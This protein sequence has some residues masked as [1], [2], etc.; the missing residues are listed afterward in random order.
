MDASTVATIASSS[1]W[2]TALTLDTTTTAN[3]GAGGIF[4]TSACSGSGTLRA[5]CILFTRATGALTGT[6]A[7]NVAFGTG[8]GTDWIKNPTGVGAFYVRI[9]MFSDVTYTTQIDSAAVAGS[10]NENIDITSKVQ[11]KLNFSV[12]GVYSAPTGACVALSGSGAVNLGDVVNG[13]LDTALAYD[14]HTYFRLNTNANGGTNV[15]YSGDTLKNIAGTNSITALTS[16]A[17]ASAVGSS[18]FGLALDTGNA[19]HSFTNLIATAP[20]AG[21]SGT[22]TNAGSALFAFS[23]ASV[24]TPVQIAGLASGTVSCDTGD[25]R[26]L[27]NIATTTKLV[28]T[29]LL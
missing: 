23:T 8:A 3:A 16:T 18:Q 9:Y 2:T 11:E 1:G 27:G 21:G 20:Y 24:T 17:T 26:Y 15:L 14:V 10:V 7:L 19:N 13:T 28:Y 25:V 6:P 5:N 22:I 12:S 4:A 29:R